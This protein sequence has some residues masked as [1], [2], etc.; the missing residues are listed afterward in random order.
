[1]IPAMR[2]Y[3]EGLEQGSPEWHEHRAGCLTAST[4]KRLLSV[5]DR[6]L[7]G[8]VKTIRGGG[9][10]IDHLEQIARGK[11]REDWAVLAY[12][13]L[14]R[15]AVRRVGLLVHAELDLVRCSPDGLVD[16][17][18]GIEVKCPTRRE[19][20]LVVLAGK[21]PDLHVDQVQFSLWVSGRSWWDLVSWRPEEPEKYRL[22]IA[23]ALPDPRK[24]AK[25]DKR[26]RALLPLLE[27][28]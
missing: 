1:M 14:R 10:S 15:V 16:P 23:R 22:G 28:A 4:A 24:F 20:H 11:D 27:A 6:G 19:E 21:I 12:E 5:T 13:L 25:F 9:K 26:V 3:L 8:F 7:P 2:D 18:G 17:D